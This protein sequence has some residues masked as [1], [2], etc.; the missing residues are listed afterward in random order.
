MRRNR[1]K[2]YTERSDRRATLYMLY[3]NIGLRSRYEPCCPTPT[4]EIN[5]RTERYN[6]VFYYCL[7]FSRHY[8]SFVV[9]PSHETVPD[10]DFLLRRMPT[11]AGLG[12][13]CLDNETP[14]GSGGGSARGPALDT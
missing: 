7:F 10:D 5:D 4:S 6:G 12:T 1:A 13:T 3:Y 14:G 11:P 8:S 9:G 2:S